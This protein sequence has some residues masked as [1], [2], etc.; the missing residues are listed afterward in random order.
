MVGIVSVELV[1][2]F[3]TDIV[4]VTVLFG[5]TFWTVATVFGVPQAYKLIDTIRTR[6]DI[7]ARTM[8][9]R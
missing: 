5:F 9:R 3:E 8:A 4:T 1:V 2:E 6:A 7:K